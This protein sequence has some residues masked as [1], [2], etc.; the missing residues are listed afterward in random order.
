MVAKGKHEPWACVVVVKPYRGYN[1]NDLYPP[2]WSQYWRPTKKKL[3]IHDQAVEPRVDQQ[4]YQHFRAARR[5]CD[6]EE[7]RS[8]VA[9]AELTHLWEPWEHARAQWRAYVDMTRKQRDRARRKAEREARRTERLGACPHRL[10]L[11]LRCFCV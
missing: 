11:S 9:Y 8:R 3:T 4:L 7:A 5:A 1:C 2:L 10:C 6:S